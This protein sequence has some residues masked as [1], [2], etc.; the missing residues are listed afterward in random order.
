MRTV[1][2]LQASGWWGLLVICITFAGF[3]VWMGIL[4]VLSLAGVEQD[5]KARAVP[6]VFVIHA[7][8]GGA[9]LVAGP[10]QF[11]RYIRD[12][13]RAL[14]RIVGRTYVFA[15]WA[16]SITGLWS[17]VFFAVDIPARIAFAAASILW[18]VATTLAFHRARQG[19]VAVHRE[20]MI[21]SFALSLFFVTFEFW[22]EGLESSGLP[23]ST[24]YPL[25][26][27]LGWFVNLLV[28]ELWI[29]L[30]RAPH[31]LAGADANALG[32]PSAV[33]RSQSQ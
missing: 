27:F 17:A 24:A 10:L 14:H 33:A 15:V 31:A 26:V 22:V 29:R 20:W 5:T 13:N 18:F 1:R 11:N 28:A 4:E 8:A 32:S 3:A 6:V 23:R 2:I 19:K 16:G 25:G 7:I 21:R 30:P 9:A 12:S